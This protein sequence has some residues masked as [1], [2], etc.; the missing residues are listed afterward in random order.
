MRK[1]NLEP[2]PLMKGGL[3]GVDSGSF[4]P[5]LPS[6]LLKGGGSVIILDKKSPFFTSQ[7]LW[8]P[9]KIRFFVKLKIEKS[10]F[11]NFTKICAHKG[12]SK[13]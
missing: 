4:Y 5:L 3:R 1:E 6:A 12:T 8:A 13:L 9:L 11:I 7:G 2:S 10:D